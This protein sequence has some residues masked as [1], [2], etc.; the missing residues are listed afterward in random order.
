MSTI[1]CQS[2]GI[3]L[4][5]SLFKI[6]FESITSIFNSSFMLFKTFAN[7]LPVKDFSLLIAIPFSV[8]V[9][10]IVPPVEIFHRKISPSLSYLTCIL[11]IFL[12]ILP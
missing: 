9:C 8:C 5:L 11:L 10:E 6:V 1:F 7:I 3:I 4:E 12:F 2:S